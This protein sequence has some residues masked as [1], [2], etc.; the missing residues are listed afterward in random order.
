MKKGG[1]NKIGGFVLV[2]VLIFLA[3]PFFLKRPKKIPPVP[4]VTKGR[5]AIVLDDWGYNLNSLEILRQIRYPLTM[6]VLPSLGYSQSAAQE[7]HRMGFE[8]ILHLPMEPLEKYH[9]EKNTIL[10]TMKEG[11]IAKIINKDLA[12][13]PY[14]VGVSNHMGSRAT[15]DLTTMRV[16]FKELRKNKLYFLDSFVSH[17]SICAVLA[18]EM[19]LSFSQRDV[20]LDNEENPAY[21]LQQI[22]KLKNK[23]RVNGKAIGIGHDR[24]ITLRVLKQIMPE[25]EKEGYKLV[26]LSELLN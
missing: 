3:I 1:F 9:L 25:L 18:R 6:S 4:V 13:V 15:E 16:V 2:L 12:S 24:K 5:I 19:S 26:Y 11:E 8:I 7:L 23:A 22:H 14:C 20:F 21:I 10:V 17:K